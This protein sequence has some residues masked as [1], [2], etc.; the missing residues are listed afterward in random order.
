MKD[1]SANLSEASV[2]NDPAGRGRAADL[3]M[4]TLIGQSLRSDSIGSTVLARRAGM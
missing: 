3:R 2:H 1:Y 4:T